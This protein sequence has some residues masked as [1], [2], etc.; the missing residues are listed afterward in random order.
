[1][2]SYPPP[3]LERLETA[4]ER[5]SH[6]GTHSRSKVMVTTA[7]LRPLLGDVARR[8]KSMERVILSDA[9]GSGEPVP[10]PA[11]LEPSDPC[12]IQYT[13]GST[14]M[15]KGVLLSHANVTSNSHAAGMALEIRRT[16]SFVS[17][18]PLYHDM[19]LIGGLLTPIYWRLPAALT[20]PL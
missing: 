8:V 14:G 6:I 3:A 11:P 10:A 20:S 4:I 1:V 5:L 16:D 19:G 7:A 18:L 15:P 13:S 17:W 9:L 2:P 12:F